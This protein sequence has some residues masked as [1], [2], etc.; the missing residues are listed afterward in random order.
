[1]T[2]NM[3]LLLPE[4]VADRQRRLEADVRRWRL[5]HPSRR[6]WARGAAT[7]E[8]A[9]RLNRGPRRT[10][11]RRIAGAAAAEVAS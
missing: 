11:D 8:P 3:H 1:M 9:S 6:R 7:A 10:S 4:L 5:A 2:M